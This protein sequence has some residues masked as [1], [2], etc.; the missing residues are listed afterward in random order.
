MLIADNIGV[1][2]DYAWGHIS[3]LDGFS[4]VT[5]AVLYSIQIYCDF[6]G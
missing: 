3:R 5:A 2:V 4:L 1:Q 6:S